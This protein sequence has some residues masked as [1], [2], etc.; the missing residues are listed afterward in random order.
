MVTGGR[1]TGQGRG[2]EGAR[3]QAQ[4]W[5]SVANAEAEAEP[6]L[7]FLPPVAATGMTVSYR[8]LRAR[9][10]GT[11]VAQLNATAGLNSWWMTSIVL[12]R[13]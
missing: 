12:G 3:G 2:G 13:W 10:L 9:I 6:E 1:K 7:L 5:A 11:P 4:S 8:S